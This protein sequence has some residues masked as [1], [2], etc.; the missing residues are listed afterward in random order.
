MTGATTFADRWALMTDGRFQRVWFMGL[1]TEAIRWLEMVAT[2]IFV[3][4]L[5]GSAFDVAIVMFCRQIPMVLL[6]R[7]MARSPNAWTAG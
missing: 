1:V 7:S 5:T 4:Q 3:F 2:A 6:V